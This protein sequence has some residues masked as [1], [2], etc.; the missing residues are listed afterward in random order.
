MQ[1]RGFFYLLSAAAEAA[2]STVGLGELGCFNKGDFGQFADHHLGD[3]VA[4]LD[5]KRLSAE[6]IEDRFDFSTIVG[7]DCAGGV[8]H[9]D[10]IFG[11][12]SAAWTDLCLVTGG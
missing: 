7:I 3:A 8:G 12:K 10:V 11:G 5:N 6:I 4:A 2:G 9:G 1:P